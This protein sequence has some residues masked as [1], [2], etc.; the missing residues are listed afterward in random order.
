ML[1]KAKDFLLFIIIAAIILCI[2]LVA[3]FLPD[4][5][6]SENENKVLAQFPALSFQTL[7]DGTF[8]MNYETYVADQ[9][10]MR[11][12]W[13]AAKSIAEFG[14]LKTENNG[15]A[16]GADGYMFAKYTAL[17]TARFTG[18]LA[19]IS[20]F[21]DALD[22]ELS[23]L[24][25]PS[26]YSVLVDKQPAGLPGVDEA[27][28]LAEIKSALGTA[29]RYVDL[30]TP[31]R[32][33]SDDYIYF[34]T[35]H[36]WTAYGAYI[37]YCAYAESVGLTP[38]AYDSLA[39]ATVDGFLGTSYSKSKAFNVQPDTITYFPA[40][41]CVSL[42]TNGETHDSLYNLD[43]FALRDKYAAFLYGNSSLIEIETTY[44]AAKRDSILI[45][46]D[47]YAD[48]LVPYLTAHYNKIVL[49][50]PRY[51]ILPFSTLAQQDF[52]DAVVLM[53]FE[54]LAGEQSVVRLGL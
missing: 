39:P 46:R 4:R 29:A 12:E 10:W 1:Q 16:Y 3:L 48:S 47:S 22:C 2:S 23:V 14:L 35:D 36:H 43:Q 41:D 20:A 13:I 24:V 17:D 37:A 30:R 51:Y 42:V 21:A 34:R 27:A 18:N 11:D 9:F 52:T 19:A 8:A 31:L 26:A 54:N 45:V 49:V 38:I 15:V 32:A 28:R 7:I 44:S 6:F 50:D 25:V 33:H 5:T 40:L 53:G